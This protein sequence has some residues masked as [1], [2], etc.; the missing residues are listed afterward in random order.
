MAT[1]SA[2]V[3]V[4]IALQQMAA[5]RGISSQTASL[6]AMACQAVRLPANRKLFDQGEPGS[7]MVI[8]A[9][10]MLR[11]EQI[12]AATRQMTAI[13]NIQHGEFIGEMALLQPEPR[14][15]RGVAATDALVYLITPERFAALE[16]DAPEA[17]CA[18]INAIT[19]NLTRRIRKVEDLAAKLAPQTLPEPTPLDPVT[20]A[21]AGERSAIGKL[22]A[23]LTKN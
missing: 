9:E 22:W 4:H 8:V 3:P 20:A 10:G 2:V 19:R 18:L 15:A 17:A 7:S 12:D 6:L 16:S 13:G 21:V 14:A 23:K 1:S 11:L 5:F